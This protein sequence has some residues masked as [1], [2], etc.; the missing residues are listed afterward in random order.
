MII[1][2]V[3]VIIIYRNNIHKLIRVIFQRYL[4]IHNN[5]NAIAT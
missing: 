5:N 2:I 3:I 1:V 4:N